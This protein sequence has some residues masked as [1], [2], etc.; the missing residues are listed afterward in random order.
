VGNLDADGATQR[1][2]CLA[3]ARSIRGLLVG[4]AGARFRLAQSRG[5]YRAFCYLSEHEP[6]PPRDGGPSRGAR[7]GQ[8]ESIFGGA[9]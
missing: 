4:Q 6:S 1:L 8:I 5:R 7:Y 9:E 2:G 3:A